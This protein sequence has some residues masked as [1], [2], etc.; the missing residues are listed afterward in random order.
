MRVVRAAYIHCWVLLTARAKDKLREFKPASAL[1]VSSLSLSS[2]NRSVVS[3]ITSAGLIY[4]R[5][6]SAGALHTGWRKRLVKVLQLLCWS[7]SE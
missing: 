7:L 2:H 6:G 3:A 1:A 4:C 5:A